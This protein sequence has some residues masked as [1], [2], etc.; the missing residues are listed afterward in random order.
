MSERI[1]LERT[2]KAT[3]DDVWEMWTTKDGIESWWG[4]DG[5]AVEVHSID[6]RVGGVLDYSMFAATPEMVK[7]MEQMKMPARSRHKMRY[8]E[9][10]RHTRIAYQHAMD[11]VPGV[12]PYEIGH[13]VEF[14]AKGDEVRMVVAFEPMHDA[15]W[16]QR[17]TA[18]W[19]MELD[20]LGKAL[21]R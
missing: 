6:L 4:P 11:F 21:A 13:A 10:T 12:A 18:G 5:F 3:L 9:V 16:T 20:K 14:F 15:I 17:A 2:Y 8:T 7:A 1:T 19:N